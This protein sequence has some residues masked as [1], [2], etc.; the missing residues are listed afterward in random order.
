[1]QIYLTFIITIMLCAIVVANC[2]N[3]YHIHRTH[4][5]YVKEW[6]EPTDGGYIMHVCEAKP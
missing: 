6:K 4:C 1:M 5:L 2:V 3:P